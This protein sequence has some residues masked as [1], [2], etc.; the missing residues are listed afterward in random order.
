MPKSETRNRIYITVPVAEVAGEG[1]PGDPALV[2]AAAARIAGL[3]KPKAIDP[4]KLEETLAGYLDVGAR[5][6]DQSVAS[7]LTID[8]VTLHLAVDAKVGLL[9]AVGVEA[10]VDVTL[11]RKVV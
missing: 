7:Q 11:K 8:S 9:F 10:A 6:F 5:L 2:K 4:S 3:F 1:P